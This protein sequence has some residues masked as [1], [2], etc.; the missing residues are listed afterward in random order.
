MSD[1]QALSLIKQYSK[2]WKWREEKKE[3]NLQSEPLLFTEIL[4]ASL[5]KRLNAKADETYDKREIK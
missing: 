4:S 5:S 2:V 1:F 3:G